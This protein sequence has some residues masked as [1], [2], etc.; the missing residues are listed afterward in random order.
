MCDISGDTWHFSCGLCD[1]CVTRRWQSAGM[2]VSL[3]AC[4]PGSLVFG[5]TL[6]LPGFGVCW[7][8]SLH[9]CEYDDFSI[10]YWVYALT[11]LLVWQRFLVSLHHMASSQPT[12]H[13]S[14]LSAR[15]SRFTES[16]D[17]GTS[18]VIADSRRL[19]PPHGW[20]ATMSVCR[21][22][23]RC[24]HRM[25]SFHATIHSSR[26]YI[27]PTSFIESSVT[28]AVAAE[29]THDMVIAMLVHGRGNLFQWQTCV[30]TNHM[31][32]ALYVSMYEVC[33]CRDTCIYMGLCDN[34]SVSNPSIRLKD[35]CD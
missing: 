1:Q 2:N 14:R 25:R 35:L 21:D 18:G 9:V 29:H 27:R 30:H 8:V 24:V 10:G 26:L 15:P 28:F 5:L 11:C 19:G 34:P 17:S 13:P 4:L 16:I 3:S 33:V 6:C 7:P 20:S 22:V 32:Y 31:T 12:T 23:P